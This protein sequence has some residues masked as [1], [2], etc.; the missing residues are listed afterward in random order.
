L[1]ADHA[2]RG[3]ESLRL[4]R[5]TSAGKTKNNIT[6]IN[7]QKKVSHASSLLDCNENELIHPDP[8]YPD[9]DPDFSLKPVTD[10][11]PSYAFPNMDPD[12]CN[13]IYIYKNMKKLPLTN[14]V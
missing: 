8:D 5:A 11:D 10:L 12:P 2:E 1:A 4:T 13:Y 3:G 6:K 9:Q 14:T 7:H